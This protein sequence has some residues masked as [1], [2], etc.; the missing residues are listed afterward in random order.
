MKIRMWFS[1]RGSQAT[2][3]LLFLAAIAVWSKVDSC[4]T[5]AT[6]RTQLTSLKIPSR[7]AGSWMARL[8]R[9]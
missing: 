1:K 7:S 4:G 3:V 5:H 9:P 2:R 8:K 6:N